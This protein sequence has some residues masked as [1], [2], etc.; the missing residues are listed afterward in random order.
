GSSALTLYI[1]TNATNLETVT[2]TGAGAFNAGDLSSF[3]NLTTF[4]ASTASGAITVEVDAAVTEISTGSGADTVSHQ[5]SGAV[6][7][8]VSLGGGDDTFFLGGYLTSA[9]INGG[10][11]T[12][13]IW[14]DG[15]TAAAASGSS[16]FAGLVTGFER[17]HI[18]N[19][20]NE[21]IDLVA[22]GGY[23]YVEAEDGAGVT[24]NG[25]VSGDTLAL[26]KDG[27]SYVVGSA[28][29]GGASDSFNIK[30]T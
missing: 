12:D 29:F 17:L 7:Q 30:L 1:E 16:T 15:S 11:G 10:Q 26:M 21:I 5:G 19:A 4:D 27:T 2:V 6:T 14:L 18:D 20:N 13:T 22:L 24:L 3:T 9:A 8:A 23:H 25:L 28:N